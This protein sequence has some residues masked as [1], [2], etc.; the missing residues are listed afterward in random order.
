MKKINY[1][2]NS[3]FR[4][5]RIENIVLVDLKEFW[6]IKFWNFEIKIF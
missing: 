3:K 4:N 2:I 6:I 5:F 1:K